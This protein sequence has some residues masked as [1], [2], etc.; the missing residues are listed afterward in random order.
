MGSQL[1][2]LRARSRIRLAL[3]AGASGRV[4]GSNGGVD[5]V[6]VLGGEVRVTHGA[7]GET[8][9]LAAGHRW[10]EPVPQAKDPE[11]VAR[12]QE[13]GDRLLGYGVKPLSPG[14][15]LHAIGELFD[16]LSNL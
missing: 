13:T 6:E 4:A 8:T 7:N 9:A 16:T 12:L 11:R 1:P 3:P 15:L 2:A 5:A 14:A 10:P